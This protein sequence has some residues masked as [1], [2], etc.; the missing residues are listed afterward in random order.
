MQILNQNILG[1]NIAR[2]RAEREWSQSDVVRELHLLGSPLSR[3]NYAKI[4]T[5][6]GNI[7]DSDLVA[8][9]EVFH[10]DFADFF[11]GIPTSRKLHHKRREK[12]E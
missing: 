11:E 1:Q 6:R 5:G 10:V 4:E 12:E 9:K 8:L 3:S 7:F 2:M